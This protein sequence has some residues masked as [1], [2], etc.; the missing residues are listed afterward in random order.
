[1]EDLEKRKH[2]ALER[3]LSEIG[4][5]DLSKAASFGAF[6][7]QKTDKG[8]L[9]IISSFGR[10]ME[11]HLPELRFVLPPEIDLF[12]LKVLALRYISKADGYPITGEWISYRDLPGGRFYAATIAPTIEEPLA[13][14]F[15]AERGSFSE[16]APRLGGEKS[17]YGDESFIFFPLPRVPL[18]V[19]LHWGDEEFSPS[20][21]LLFDR[22]CSHYLNTDDLKVMGS[23]LASLLIKTKG[24][25][26]RGEEYLLW[27]VE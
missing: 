12:S 17:D 10:I 2:Q 9:L 21:R 13:R 1:M 6:T 14:T 22:C 18:L 19:V 8:E 7:H 20:S 5:R 11:I 26:Y 23:Q 24:G 16:I 15:G 3:A 4:D 27:M 25:V